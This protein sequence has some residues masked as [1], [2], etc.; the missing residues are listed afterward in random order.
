MHYRALGRTGW[1][2]SEIGFGPWAIGAD[3][4]N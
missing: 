3:W 4:G 2:V 1:N